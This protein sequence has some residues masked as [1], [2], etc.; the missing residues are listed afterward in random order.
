HRACH[1]RLN[2]G[3]A[4]GVR[5][6][7]AGH[8]STVLEQLDGDCGAN[9]HDEHHIRRK[10]LQLAP[11]GCGISQRDGVGEAEGSVSQ[12]ERGSA[13]VVHDAGELEQASAVAPAG[14]SMTPL[15]A[16]SPLAPLALGSSAITEL[17]VRHTR[18]AISSSD[19]AQ[20][21]SRVRS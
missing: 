19:R 6:H 18:D 14:A 12:V 13:I 15:A 20:K 5:G 1:R 21:T 16:L 17:D 3:I 4:G 2:A 9:R 10:I 7:E 8:W 11:N